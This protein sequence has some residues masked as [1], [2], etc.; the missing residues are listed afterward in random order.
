VDEGLLI[1]ELTEADV[2]AARRVMMRSVLED[3][4]DS[5]DPVMHADVDDLVGAYMRPDGA[6]MFVVVDTMTGD[7][8]ATGGVRTGA[9]QPDRVPPQLA[10]LERRY[11]EGRTGQ[12]VRVYVLKEHRRRGIARALVQAIID[13]VR[14]DAHYERL[15][16]HT[17]PHSPG[18]LAFW[19]AMGFK[20]VLDDV[21]ASRQIFFELP[22]DPDHDKLESAA[23][24]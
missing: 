5:Y 24:T 23:T 6:F 13:R 20:E 7:L 21:K 4:A 18:A 9:F 22:P 19:T 11:R 12:I 15:A 1:R 3:F 2:P 17:Y 14:D 16:L 8:L 10:L